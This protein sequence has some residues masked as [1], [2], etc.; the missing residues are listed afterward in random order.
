MALQQI[1][2]GSIAGGL[3]NTQY[4]TAQGTY[5]SS[6]GVDPDFPVKASDNR[7]SGN[8][9]PVAYSTF[10][11]GDISDYPK[12][13]LTNIKDELIYVYSEDGKIVSYTNALSAETLVGTATAG[14]GNGA[15]YYNN[16]LY[17]ATPTD[18]SR[19]GP[20]DGVPVLTNNVWTGATLG[21]QVATTDTTYPNIRGSFMPNHVMHRHGDNALY[22]AD[23]VDG[24]GVLHRIKTTTG[25]AQ[26]DTDDNSAFNV[27]DFP[28][29][30]LP[31]AVESWGTDLV[32]ACIETT[33]TDIAQG[34]AKLFFWDTFASSFYREVALPDPIVTAIKNVN[35]TLFVWT[36][37]S[38]SGVRMS[39][40][41]G[42]ETVADVA[43]IENSPPPL[44]GAVDFFGTK[45]SFGTYLT[46]PEDKAVIYSFGSK[47]PFMPKGTHVPVVTQATGV[48]KIVTACKYAQQ[49]PNLQ[50][51]IIAGW[52]DDTAKGIDKYDAAG[53]L[54]NKIRT[55]VFNVNQE[56]KIE[57]IRV[58]F[59]KAVG[60]N[61]VIT[62]K[63]YFDD[64]TEIRTL[65]VVNDTNYPNGER[66]VNFKNTELKNYRAKNNFY[67]EFTWTGTDPLPIIL[68]IQILI[69]IEEDE[70]NLE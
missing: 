10:S 8:M 3:A 40:Y 31:V 69:D 67:L 60:A 58:A 35:G 52:G 9:V 41:I 51:Q 4:L 2:I 12:W 16:F 29:G 53:T 64:E 65:T 5:L 23:V 47:N 61:M 14:A 56:F 11:G 68:P 48:N 66:I 36:G 54:N 49:S 25:V 63:V 34:K 57:D 13:M 43:Y 42:G 17:F 37:N 32:V 18:V 50:P 26:G 15:E 20:L 24:R 7:M 70:D 27:I 30:V 44:A 38:N 59:G 39:H 21:S 55:G 28:S 6:Y 62:P 46:Y 33:S 19:Y 22:F 45:I 1:T